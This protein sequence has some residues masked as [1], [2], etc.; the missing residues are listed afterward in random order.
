MDSGAAAA[1]RRQRALLLDGGMPLVIYSG[2]KGI[3]AYHRL[4]QAHG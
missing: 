2:D 4:L 1:D 3:E